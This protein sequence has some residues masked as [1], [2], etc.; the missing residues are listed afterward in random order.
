MGYAMVTPAELRQATGFLFLA[1]SPGFAA[2]P[3]AELW[4]L[5]RGFS[6]GVPVDK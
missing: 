3:P 1:Q 2:H 6:R 4:E 5:L